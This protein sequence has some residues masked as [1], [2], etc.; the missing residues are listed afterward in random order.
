MAGGAG[1]IVGVK[2]HQPIERGLGQDAQKVAVIA[3]LESRQEMGQVVIGH[4]IRS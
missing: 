3:R 4:R 2:V 1:G